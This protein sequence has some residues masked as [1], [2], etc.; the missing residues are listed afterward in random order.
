MLPCR[1]VASVIGV[2]P[3]P[4]SAGSRVVRL[5]E[6]IGPETRLDLASHLA[7]EVGLK[8]YKFQPHISIKIQK[9]RIF[10]IFGVIPNND[11]LWNSNT[12]I[13]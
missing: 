3:D 1:N 7:P 6:A 2:S 13:S 8:I 10:L 12:F 5:L 4:A 9:I 11:T